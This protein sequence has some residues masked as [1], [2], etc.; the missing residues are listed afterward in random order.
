MFS[1]ITQVTKA[2]RNLNPAG[3]RQDA[4]RDLIVALVA[5]SPQAQ[6]RMENFFAPAGLSEAKRARVSRMLRWVT[7]L[8]RNAV[9]DLEIWDSGLAVPEGAFVFDA[10]HPELLVA[11]LLERRE[12]LAIRLA[13]NFPPFRKPVVDSIVRAVAKEN[14]LFSAA[15]AIP[16]IVPLLS[17][18]WALGEFASDTA[19]L[20]MNQVRMAF[21]I[22]AASDA[23]VGYGSQKAAIGSIVASAFGLRAIARQLVAKVPF[24]GGVIPKAAIAWSGTWAMG[25]SMDRLY[26]LGYLAAPGRREPHTIEVRPLQLPREIA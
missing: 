8:N 11:K 6:W 16:D 24:G 21:M 3:V 19:F 26:A 20:T 23:P 13:R 18:P 12:D 1:A 17:I 2:L 4:G 22:A 9:C 7:P 15:T 10:A 5:D 25:R 14:M